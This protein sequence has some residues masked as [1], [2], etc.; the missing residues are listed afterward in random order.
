M[1]T[2]YKDRPVTLQGV[3]FTV[4]LFVHISEG[5]FIFNR[6]ISYKYPWHLKTRRRVILLVIFSCFWFCFSGFLTHLLKP[7]LDQGEPIA[8]EIYYATIILSILF[9]CIYVV[10]LITYN[11][12]QSLSFFLVENERLKQD[13][14]RL[15]YRI[16]QDQINPHFLFNNLSTLIAIIRQDQSTAIRFAENFSDVYRYVLQSKDN[17]SIKLEDELTFIKAYLALHQERLGKGLQVKID[18]EEAL[19]TSH[20]PPLSLQFLVE[21]AIKHNVATRITPLSISLYSKND[22]LV[23][24]NNLNPKTTT[25]SNNT[26]LKNLKKRYRFLTQELLIIEKNDKEFTVELPLIRN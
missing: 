9:V 20:L 4:C 1:L 19:L 25:Y 14:L 18:I 22:K 7:F 24:R 26:G 13:K 2:L 10:L 17:T 3:V 16:L 11:Y 21:N 5:I 8:P 23:V 6:L 15:D 12:H